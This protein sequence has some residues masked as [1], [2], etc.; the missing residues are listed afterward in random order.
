MVQVD[1]SENGVD[2]LVSKRHMNVVGLEKLGQK[3]TQFFAVECVVRV[4]VELG[5]VLVDLLVE[6]G[7]VGIKFF[8][9][10][11]G[12]RKFVALKVCRVDHF[13]FT[14]FLPNPIISTY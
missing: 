10:L 13:I 7:G 9:V 12:G 2:I 14:L 11:Q 6:F 4:T 1:L 3:L 8:Q 5:E